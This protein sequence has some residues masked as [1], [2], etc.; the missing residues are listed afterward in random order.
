MII[1]PEKK[2]QIGGDNKISEDAPVFSF[3]KI[4]IDFIYKQGYT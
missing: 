3:R 1:L 2:M 4:P